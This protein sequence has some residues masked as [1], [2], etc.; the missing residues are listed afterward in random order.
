MEHALVVTDL[1]EENFGIPDSG[2][3]PGTPEHLSAFA[4]P[5]LVFWARKDGGDGRRG[6]KG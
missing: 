6:D 3:E 2:A 4:P 5:W 1:S